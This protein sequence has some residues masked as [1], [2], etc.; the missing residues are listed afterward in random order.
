MMV[1]EWIGAEHGGFLLVSGTS[2]GGVRC[3]EFVK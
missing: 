2:G 3:G 1:G